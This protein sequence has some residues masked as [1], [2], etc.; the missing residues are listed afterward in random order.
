MQDIDRKMAETRDSPEAVSEE[1][2]NTKVWVKGLWPLSEGPPLHNC[3]VH[4]V[5]NIIDYIKLVVAGC[6]TLR[7]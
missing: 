2:K 5:D 7:R 4:R 1:E 6:S 3:G